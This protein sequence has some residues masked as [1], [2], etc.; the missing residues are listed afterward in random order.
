MALS[1]ARWD[2]EI[3]LSTELVLFCPLV[4][5][6]WL[7][8]FS[9]PVYSNLGADLKQNPAALI[10]WIKQHASQMRSSRS[11]PELL[12]CSARCTIKACL[13]MAALEERNSLFPSPS[14]PSPCKDGAGIPAA[15]IPGERR[16][17][18]L[19][20]LPDT[21]DV[22]EQPR[23]FG[24]INCYLTDELNQPG[25]ELC[26]W[27]A[28][29]CPWCGKEEKFPRGVCT[30]LPTQRS[31]G[32]E[33][34]LSSPSDPPCAPQNTFAVQIRLFLITVCTSSLLWIFPCDRTDTH[35]QS[36]RGCCTFMCPFLKGCKEMS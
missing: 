1:S 7:P 28:V 13:R 29:S 18:A 33:T 8:T 16:M 10:P 27:E 23:C 4:L 5:T 26:C 11:C 22:S 36:L 32:L 19:R 15:S 21:G 17:D 35:C 12:V 30:S 34:V 25:G 14:A 9:N 3:I 6:I 2:K 20:T 24:K 31:Q